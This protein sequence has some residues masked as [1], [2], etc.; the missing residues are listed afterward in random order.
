M[1]TWGVALKTLIKWSPV[2]FAAVRKY[3][4]YLQNNPAAQRFTSQLVEQT[5]RIPEKLSPDLRAQRKIDAVRKSLAEA[6]VLGVDPVQYAA[7][8]ADLDEMSRVLALSKAASRSRR[9]T[10][11]RDVNRRVD[12][13]VV[14][15]LPALVAKPAPERPTPRELPSS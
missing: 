10:I 14:Q 7:W 15:I 8:R 5:A 11:V 9:R 6:A 12:A 2:V 4:P 3:Y 13:L 1:P